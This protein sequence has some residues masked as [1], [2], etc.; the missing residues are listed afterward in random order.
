VQIR[1]N[2]YAMQ[3][4]RVSPAI[5]DER[6]SVDTG[7][8]ERIR[9]ER[10]TSI[11]FCSGDE[12]AALV[13]R[14]FD[15]PQEARNWRQA[16]LLRSRPGRLLGARKR[17]ADQSHSRRLCVHAANGKQVLWTGRQDDRRGDDAAGLARGESQGCS[18]RRAESP[19]FRLTRYFCDRT[20]PATAAV[21]QLRWPSA[22]T[23]TLV[24]RIAAN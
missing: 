24:W 18:P 19:A 21:W 2:V 13:W 16:R 23:A 9:Q 11:G 20:G 7:A 8:D 5:G 15:D 14:R 1:P 3:P 12:P 10:P 17:A 6:S 22:R 4:L